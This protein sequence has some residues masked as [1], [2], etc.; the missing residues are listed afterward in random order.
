MNANPALPDIRRTSIGHQSRWT[1]I[2][3]PN[4]LN[5]CG[6]FLT[7]APVEDLYSNIFRHTALGGELRVSTGN[8]GIQK[9]R[10]GNGQSPTRARQEQTQLLGIA[11]L[12]MHASL[13]RI[14]SHIRRAEGTDAR[15]KPKMQLLLHRELGML[16][17]NSV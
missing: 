8:S 3:S 13:K 6:W 2:A 17:P 12:R 1:W 11:S 10:G 7:I 9:P 15:S 14:F 16:P 5:A 4:S